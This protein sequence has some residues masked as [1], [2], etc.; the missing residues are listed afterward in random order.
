MDSIGNF[1]RILVA[2][3]DSPYSEKAAKYGFHIAKLMNAQVAL[4]NVMDPPATSITSDPI[5][6]QQPFITP[7]ISELKEEASNT[8]LEKF[9]EGWEGEQALTTFSKLGNPRIEILATA[10]E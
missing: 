2:V 3:E 6:G 4:L 8:V 9:S 7:E 5:L 10:H 1:K